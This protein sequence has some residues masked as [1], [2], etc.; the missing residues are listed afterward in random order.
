VNSEKAEEIR[1]LAESLDVENPTS[2]IL[3]A[4]DGKQFQGGG[5]VKGLG[6]VDKV[7]LVEYLICQLGVSKEDV[8][9]WRRLNGE[10][11]AMENIL[12]GIGVDVS[13]LL[14]ESYVE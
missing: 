8:D 11:M 12:S 4:S 6:A 14:E 7:D 5:V 10:N 1:L 9:E 2:Y 3:I 13:K